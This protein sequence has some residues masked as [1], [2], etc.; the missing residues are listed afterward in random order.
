MRVLLLLPLYVSLACSFS[1]SLSPSHTHTHSFDMSL[2]AS[3][4]LCK[5]A[6]NTVMTSTM[7]SNNQ[8]IIASTIQYI[9]IYT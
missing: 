4:A 5:P 2:H 9:Y 1:L 7:L 6:A 3:H 8:Y